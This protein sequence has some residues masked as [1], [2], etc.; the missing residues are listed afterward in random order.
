MYKKCQ[1][2]ALCTPLCAAAVWPKGGNRGQ[3]ERTSPVMLRLKL[4]V[5]DG[6]LPGK[7]G[8]AHFSSHH[9]RKNLFNVLFAGY[10]PWSQ[11]HYLKFRYSEKA[12][13]RT[14]FQQPNFQN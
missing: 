2:A 1:N 4:S 12:L 14:F 3:P 11:V 7:A 8:L 5:I 6:N 10:S 13:L 9:C